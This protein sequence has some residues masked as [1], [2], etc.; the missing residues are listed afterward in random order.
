M[1]TIIYGG[2]V[3]LDGFLAGTDDALDW[4]HFSA[5][6]Q[7][8]MAESLKD[9]DTILMGRKTYAIAAASSPRH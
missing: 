2:A 7:A 8:V 5:D 4:L 6:V 9:V 1:R 3:S